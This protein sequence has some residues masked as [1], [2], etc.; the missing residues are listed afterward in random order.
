MSRRIDGNAHDNDYDNEEE[1]ASW[2]LLLGVSGGVKFA[3]D[4]E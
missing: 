4:L 2:T 3:A 1:I